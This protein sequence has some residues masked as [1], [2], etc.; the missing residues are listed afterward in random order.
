MAEDYVDS[1][2]LRVTML[3]GYADPLKRLDTSESVNLHKCLILLNS[4]QIHATRWVI[5][6]QLAIVAPW[7]KERHPTAGMVKRALA[8]MFRNVSV[9]AV[10]DRKCRKLLT[11]AANM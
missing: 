1:I 8:A 9:L 11:R 2:V 5:A 10:W 6:R 7:R 3:Y 4:C